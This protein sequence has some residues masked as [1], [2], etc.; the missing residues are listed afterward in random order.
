MMTPSTVIRLAFTPTHSIIALGVRDHKRFPNRT[1][2]CRTL[3]GLLPNT[4]S[5]CDQDLDILTTSSF[6][7]FCDYP[8]HTSRRTTRVQASRN[9]VC[10][11]EFQRLR[12]SGTIQH[13]RLKFI[14]KQAISAQAGGKRLTLQ[15]LDVTATNIVPALLAV[16]KMAG[17]PS[18]SGPAKQP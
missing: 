4:C 15:I 11:R 3:R 2:H 17:R 8:S 18:G 1:V 7:S 5:T 9:S 12:V 6:T 16:K 10:D 14:Y 13:S